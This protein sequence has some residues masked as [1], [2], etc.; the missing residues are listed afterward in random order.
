ML[1]FFLVSLQAWMGFYNGNL[2]VCGW[3]KAQLV[4]QANEFSSYIGLRE[5]PSIEAKTIGKVRTKTRARTTWRQQ[6][7]T[8]FG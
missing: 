8:N 5:I 3:D 1:V 2:R 4:A 7:Q 6:S